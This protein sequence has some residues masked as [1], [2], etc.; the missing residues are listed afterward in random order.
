MPAVVVEVVVGRV[1]MA[2]DAAG[3][4]QRICRTKHPIRAVERL[5]ITT[6]YGRVYTLTALRPQ[7]FGGK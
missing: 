1:E 5:T 7:P 4:M 6:P 3:G 2:G